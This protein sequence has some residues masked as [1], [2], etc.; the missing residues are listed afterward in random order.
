MLFALKEWLPVVEACA[1]GSNTILF[2]RGGILDARFDARIAPKTPQ[3]QQP[4]HLFF[5]TSFHVS[6]DHQYLKRD[7]TSREHL[8][9]VSS[10]DIRSDWPEI[11]CHAVFEVTGAWE[12]TNPHIGEALDAFHVYGPAFI[13]K[14]LGGTKKG[15][16]TVLEVKTYRL[17][18]PIILP[19][20][21]SLYGC[22]SWLELDMDQTRL[23]ACVPCVEDFTSRQEEV[24]RA[25]S[26]VDGTVVDL[27]AAL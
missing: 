23:D 11:P 13:D 18:D 24:R 21:A 26:R 16:L 12:T 19:Q 17:L 4:R 22:F 6:T 27:I 14:R 3:Q 5:P 20:E 8:E 9:A 25:L 1:Q 10:V 2:R 15:P 7:W